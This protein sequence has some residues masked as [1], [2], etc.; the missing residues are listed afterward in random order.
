MAREIC[1][2]T[3]SRREILSR[4]KHQ[5]ST[6]QNKY[7]LSK[8]IRKVPVRMNLSCCSHRHDKHLDNGDRKIEEQMSGHCDKK[9]ELETFKA[10]FTQCN[11]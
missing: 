7:S 10:A 4:S 3:C 6:N 11:P 1:F 2:L 8:Q 9:W 5:H